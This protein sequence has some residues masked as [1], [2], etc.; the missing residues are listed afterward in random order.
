MI[1]CENVTDGAIYVCCVGVMSLS[2]TEE[3]L[4]ISYR[5]SHVLAVLCADKTSE[6]MS[7]E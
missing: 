5:L 1:E 7:E 6:H 4:C 2:M 3:W